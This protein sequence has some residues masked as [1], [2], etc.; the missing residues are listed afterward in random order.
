M[1]WQRVAGAPLWGVGV[2]C[3]ECSA[4][5]H[6]VDRAPDRGGGTI[7]V[8]GPVPNSQVPKAPQ[9]G[10]LCITLQASSALPSELDRALRTHL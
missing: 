2:T 4:Y 7:E 5:R 6:A 8:P 9:Q 1:V 10:N 3:A